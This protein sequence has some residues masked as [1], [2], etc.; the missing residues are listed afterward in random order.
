MANHSV[1][2]AKTRLSQLID[3]ALKGEDVV[4]TRHGHP[5]VELKPVSPPPRRLTKPDIEWLQK[6]RIPRRGST[7]DAATLVS[8]M[9]DEDW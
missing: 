3:L 6:H 7:E 4:I 1:A 5:V 2:E 8:R 9:R